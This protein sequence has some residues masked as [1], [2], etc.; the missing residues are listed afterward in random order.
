MGTEKV[1]RSHPGTGGLWE[2]GS[3]W[4]RVH[5]YLGLV[6]GGEDFPKEG[7]FEWGFEG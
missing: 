2:P 1:S 3:K 5:T 4:Q 6:A 7:T